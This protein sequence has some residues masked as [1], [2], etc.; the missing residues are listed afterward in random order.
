MA[1]SCTITFG[2]EQY[3]LRLNLLSRPYVNSAERWEQNAI[4]TL[5]T[6]RTGMFQAKISTVI[7]PVELERLRAVLIE[8]DRQVGHVVEAS[9]ELIERVLELT[10]TLTP[11]G[12]LITHIVLYEDPAEDTH[13]RFTLEIDQS[14]ISGLIEQINEALLWFPAI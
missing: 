4:E 7:W 8:L 3:H 9:F 2:S 14:Y 11:Q 6:A 5:V 13:L 12:R 10:F 1:Q